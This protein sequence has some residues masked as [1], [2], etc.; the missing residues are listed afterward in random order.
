MCSLVRFYGA[1]HREGAISIALEYMDG[2]ALSNLIGQIGSVPEFALANMTYQML[3]G[4]AYLKHEKRLHRD[5][6]PSNMLI[7]SLGQ[8]KLTDFGVS[9]E[10]RNSIGTWFHS[11]LLA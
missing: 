4:M 6:K 2:G 9:A 1:F 10:L 5:I 11:L 3:W 8:V 7:N